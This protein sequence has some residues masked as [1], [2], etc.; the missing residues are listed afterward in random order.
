MVSGTATVPSVPEDTGSPSGASIGSLLGQTTVN[1]SDAT[2]TVTTAVS[3]GS[4]G[5]PAAG[6]AITGNSATPDQG[7]YQYSTDNGTTWISIPATGL[8]DTNAI[9]IPTTAELR[10]VPWRT[11]TAYPAN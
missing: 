5:T 11:S 1:Y 9:V 7:T 10:F 4:V 8:G 2:D 3:G 6:I